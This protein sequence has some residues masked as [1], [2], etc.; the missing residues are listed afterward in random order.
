MV[1]GVT[2][3][4]MCRRNTTV[5]HLE[6]HCIPMDIWKDCR[7]GGR[8]SVLMIYVILD[9]NMIH[10]IA[11][12]KKTTLFATLWVLDQKWVRGG[13]DVS[14]PY[15]K[16]PCTAPALKGAFLSPPSGRAGLEKHH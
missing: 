16:R 2:F 1:N 9:V 4:P 3:L 5:G 14:H 6:S 12:C 10:I 7:G 8:L 13:G 11:H 15:S